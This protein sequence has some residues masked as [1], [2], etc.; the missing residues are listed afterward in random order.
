MSVR[1][2]Y[3]DPPSKSAHNRLHGRCVRVRAASEGTS[4]AERRLAALK[5]A[6]EASDRV[7]SWKPQSVPRSGL[8][9]FVDVKEDPD[10]GA[11]PRHVDIRMYDGALLA[12]QCRFHMLQVFVVR[13]GMHRANCIPHVGLQCF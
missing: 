13:P 7:V 2:M 5:A 11:A 4:E 3:V 1:S 8:S 12:Q 10:I 9:K 6:Q